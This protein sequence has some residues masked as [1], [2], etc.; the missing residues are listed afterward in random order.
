MLRSVDFPYNTGCACSKKVV[1]LMR[2]EGL[3]SCSRTHRKPDGMWFALIGPALLFR[4]RRM[5]QRSGDG[6][7][8]GVGSNHK[9]HGCAAFRPGNNQARRELEGL[10]DNSDVSRFSRR[11][12]TTRRVVDS[13][14]K[15][16]ATA[17]LFFDDRSG[18]LP[19]R[20]C[21]EKKA[22]FFFSA[23]RLRRRGTSL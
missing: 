6:T 16:P 8:R 14:T 17:G 9:R 10:S 18:I 22:W 21:Y 11:H 2:R 5:W 3:S 19:R 7:A 23:R 20:S 15:S 4:G 1:A 12:Q 13:E